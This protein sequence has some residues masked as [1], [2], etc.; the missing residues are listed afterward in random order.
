MLQK[1]NN[2]W[3]R[4]GALAFIITTSLSF[5]T[6][7]TYDGVSDDGFQLAFNDNY[8]IY[9]LNIPES[10][11]FAK[12]KVPLTD[13]EIMERLDR[14]LLVNTYWQSQTLLFIKR[15][16]RDFQVIEPILE[17]YG[18]PEDF[19]YLAV[20]ESGL[21]NVVSPAGATGYWQIL[22]GTAEENGLEVS[23]EV[24][25]RYHLEKATEA[26]CKYLLQSYQNF[27]S[28]T[29]AAASYNMGRDGLSKQ[30]VRQGGNSY[31]DLILNSETGR[32]LFRIMAVKQILENPEKHGFHFRTKDLYPVVP[33]REVR[34]DSAITDLAV[35]A[36]D[37]GINYRILKYH[38]PWLRVEYLPAKAGK[39]YIISIPEAGYFELSPEREINLPETLQTDS[40]A[41]SSD[42]KQK[43]E[44]KSD[45]EF[46]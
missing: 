5:L 36:E 9:A 41:Q 12:E 10:I 26:A 42:N 28:W 21:S 46:R 39:E 19:K 27:N 31:Y 35:F 11:D 2:R 1:N 40:A 16:H 15:S 3:L 20:I 18:V 33:V 7:Y 6:Y 24:D 38:N 17:K 8:G 14:E 30:L 32:Y 23:N 29:L 4:A 25:E 22:K 34:V 44:P 43:L 13:P 37:Q 45:E